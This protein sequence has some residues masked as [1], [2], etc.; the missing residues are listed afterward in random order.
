[1]KLNPRARALLVVAGATLAAMAAIELAWVLTFGHAARSGALERL[2]NRRPEKITIAFRE[3]SSWWPGLVRFEGLVVRG[4]T[5]RVDWEVAIDAG[6]AQLALLPLVARRAHFRAVEA[7][8]VE[9]RVDRKG[10]EGEGEGAARMPPGGAGGARGGGAAAAAAPAAAAPPPAPRRP[11]WSFDFRNVRVAGVRS[12]RFDEL[13]FT[14]RAAGRG[15]FE[16][17]T[18]AGRARVA[19]VELDIAEAAVAFRGEPVAQGLAGA[20][21]VDL[22]SWPYRERRG[23]ALLPYTSGRLRLAGRLDDRAILRE[24]LRRAPWVEI[25]PGYAE[26]D[27]DLRLSRGRLLSGSRLTGERSA[28]SVRWLDFEITGRNELA[29]E[30]NAPDGEPTRARWRVSFADYALQRDGAEAPLLVGRGLA[31]AGEASDLELA[32]LAERSELR[33]ELGEAELPD[34]ALF[35]PWLPPSARL[36][37]LEGSAQVSGG[38]GVQVADRSARGRIEARFERARVRWGEL[39]LAGRIESRIEI[40]GGDIESRRLDVSGSRVLL[41]DFRSPQL[42]PNERPA[43]AGLPQGWW[44]DLAFERGELALG[45]PVEAEATFR[46]RVRDTSPLVALFE[47]RRDLPRWAERALNVEDVGATGRFRAGPAS[48]HLEELQSPVFGGVLH[49]RAAFAGRTTRRGQ[50]LLS[51]RRFHLGA[52]FDGDR[53]EVRLRNA[54]DWFEAGGR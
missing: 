15:G 43:A 20:L 6:R 39:E 31:L 22:A 16:V 47:L 42:T 34:I 3:A 35:A 8:G 25:E 52:G 27:V 13:D 14:G 46:A 7:E 23:R 19:G 37:L 21:E 32:H 30:V 26:L 36:E 18:P 38:L 48:F 5:P 45:P 9:V 53:R 10:T 12:V 44:G 49:A 50:L 40:V 17:H 54:R 2:L 41:A 24:L 11:R 51:W 4:R 1:M 28:R 33:L 29:L